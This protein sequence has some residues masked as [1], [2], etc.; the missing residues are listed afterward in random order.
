MKGSGGPTLVD[1]DIWKDFL[2]SKAFN[3]ASQQQLCQSIADLAKQL[4]TEEIDP[5]CLTEYIACR[6]IPLDKGPSK[7][8]KP[9]VRPIGVGEVLRRLVGKLL[10][11]VIK[12]DICKHALVYELA[13]KLPYML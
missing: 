12:D 10:L 7:D 6:L 9:G 8:G 2:C 5:I 11:G 1:S 3:N 13:L 4:C